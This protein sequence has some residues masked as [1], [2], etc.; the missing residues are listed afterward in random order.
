MNAE[1]N[2]ELK[3]TMP[4]NLLP[5]PPPV[6]SHSH[7]GNDSLLITLKAA[8]SLLTSH[9]GAVAYPEANHLEPAFK[10]LFLTGIISINQTQ[11]PQPGVKYFEARLFNHLSIELQEKLG[12]LK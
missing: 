12:M 11:S 3:L 8:L 4:D 9:H 5:Q 7:P 10:W 2:L 6:S 1:Q